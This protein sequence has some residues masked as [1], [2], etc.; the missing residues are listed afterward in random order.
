MH[1]DEVKIAVKHVLDEARRDSTI[2][3]NKPGDKWLQLFLK[4]HPDIKKKQTELISKSRASV[5]EEKLREW[6]SQVKSYLEENNLISVLERPESIFNGDETGVQLCPKSGRLLGPRKE[7]NFYEISSGKEKE[8]ITVLCSFSAAG[9]SLPPM[10]MF[11][12]KRI[13][14]HLTQS[15][16]ADWAI[17]R[18]ESG[19]MVSSTFFEYMANVFYPWCVRE[20]V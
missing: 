19:W 14:A 2:K 12:Y 4:R 8:A 7:R 13:P 15:V 17:G 1:P 9:A 16:L 10:I 11:P 6:F 3:D 5:T 18:S 20:K